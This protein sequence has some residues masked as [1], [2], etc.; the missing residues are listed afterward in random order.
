MSDN[1]EM[2]MS[3]PDEVDLENFK[4][5][6]NLWYFMYIKRKIKQNVKPICTEFFCSQR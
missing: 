3:T 2:S 4:V 1:W 6:W 5:R